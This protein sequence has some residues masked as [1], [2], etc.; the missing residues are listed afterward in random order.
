MP[1]GS[2]V[3]VERLEVDRTCQISE[4]HCGPATLQMLLARLGVA[5]TQEQLAD[6]GGACETIEE[7]GMRVDQLAHAVRRLAP[8]ARFWFKEHAS[9]DD[10]KAIVL[11]HHYA[12]GVE[13]QGIFEDG[14]DDPGHYSLVTFIDEEHEQIWIA[15]P[16]SDYFE[17]DRM[18]PIPLFL[19]RWWDTNEVLDPETN[20]WKIVED[21]R[22]LFIVTPE[23]ERFPESLGMTKV[24]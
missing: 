12:A 15:D 19:E 10:L 24:D 23:H 11:D 9:L 21:Y 18:L 16:Y 20:E 17:Q 22:M 4:S 14:D 6:A 13:W 3:S 5:A 1:S 2:S 7:S 8:G